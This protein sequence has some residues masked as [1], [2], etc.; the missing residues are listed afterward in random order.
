[1]LGNGLAY[2]VY[3]EEDCRRKWRGLRD[4]YQRDRRAEKEK[5]RSG[6][7]ASGQQPWRF[8]YVL[9]FLDPFIVPR[10]TSGNFTA[11]PST[12]S[13]TSV[14][15]TGASRPSMSPTTATIASTAAARPS[16]MSTSST[17]MTTTGAA[18]SST[19]S[20]SSTSITTI[21]AARSSTMSTSSTS[22]TTIG[23]ARPSTMSTSSTSIT[24]IGA[25]RSSTM[26]TSSTSMTTIGAARSSTMSTS[27][28]SITTIGTAMED[29][30][31]EEAPLDLGPPEIIMNLTE[32]T[33]EDLVEQDV[34]V[35]TNRERNEE[36]QRHTRR[37]RRF[38]IHSTHF[39][40]GSSKPSRGMQPNLMLTGR[41][42]KRPSLP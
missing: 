20:T 37:H 17:S 26:S 12:T 39:S 36:E 27:S 33:T 1:M 38:Q 29:D 16:T 23:A 9:S 18:R 34:A 10:A 7:A 15:P 28:T 5:K 11:R 19:M 22:M 42:M 2:H 31:M 4:R 40:R 32:V 25:A 13:S 21:G 41:R 35:E 14:V 24:T 3:V 30:E 8:C 6:S